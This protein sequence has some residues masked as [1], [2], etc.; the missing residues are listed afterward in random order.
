MKTKLLNCS[1]GARAKQLYFQY[2]KKLNSSM[3]G[4]YVGK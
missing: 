1:M 3:R 2:K 4:K